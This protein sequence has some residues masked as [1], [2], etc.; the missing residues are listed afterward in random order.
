VVGGVGCEVGVGTDV[1]VGT[2]RPVGAGVGGAVGIGVAPGCVGPGVVV[3][4]PGTGVP[5]D[6]A[7]DGCRPGVA[8]GLPAGEG[9]GDGDIWVMSSKCGPGARPRLLGNAFSPRGAENASAV[10]ATMPAAIVAANPKRKTIRGR[11]AGS[12]VF[13][14][15]RENA[16]RVGVRRMPSAQ[17]P[18]SG[19]DP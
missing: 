13:C 2:G 3:A 10:M 4:A 19:A 5:P 9:R 12:P 14:A 6:G 18:H 7:T 8:D 15:D 1:G 16:A 11:D 17:S